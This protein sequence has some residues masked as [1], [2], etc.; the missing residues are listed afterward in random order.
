MPCMTPHDGSTGVFL[1]VTALCPL[2]QFACSFLHRQLCPSSSSSNPDCQLWC[3]VAYLHIVAQFPRTQK[4]QGRQ[5]GPHPISSHSL[6]CVRRPRTV[7][8]RNTQSEPEDLGPPKLFVPFSPS[9]TP[10][11][12]LGCKPT[13]A[14][15]QP[16]KIQKRPPPTSFSARLG[17]KSASASP[18]GWPLE[19]PDNFHGSERGFRYLFP[20]HTTHGRITDL[21]LYSIII[22]HR[23]NGVPRRIQG[24]VRLRSAV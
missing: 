9:T 22:S 12:C 11:K 8:R 20:P 16:P 13:P 15:H 10:N 7:P 23:N 19:P 21:L 5:G 6:R 2:I 1:H 24:C 4:S 3:A 14:P 18:L 17:C